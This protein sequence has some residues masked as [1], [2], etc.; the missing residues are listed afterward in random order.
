MEIL[1]LKKELLRENKN[2]T[3]GKDVFRET[4]KG[5]DKIELDNSLF[6]VALGKYE[7][8]KSEEILFTDSIVKVEMEDDVDI[9][10][11]I[12]TIN[13]NRYAF[14]MATASD[15]KKS[16]CIFIKEEY[17]QFGQWLKEQATGGVEYNLAEKDI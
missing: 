16:N 17:Y 9:I 14:Y 13:D 1:R 2:K 5:I 4:Y 11:R 10:D 15:L 3:T 7:G 6:T 12:I 8:V